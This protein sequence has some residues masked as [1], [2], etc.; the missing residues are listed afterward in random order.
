MGSGEE[1]VITEVPEQV[2]K[3]AERR[4]LEIFPNT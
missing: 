1:R 2:R 3:I 4:G